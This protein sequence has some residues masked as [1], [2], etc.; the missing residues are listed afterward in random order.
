MISKQT[1][2]LFILGFLV[3]SLVTA[4]QAVPGYMD[5]DYYYA[6]A[7]RIANGKGLTEPFLWNY[8]EDSSRIVHPSHGYWMPLSSFIAAAG[9]V[10]SGARTFFAARGG[11]LLLAASIPPLTYHL[12]RR[13][14]ADQRSA[15]LAGVLACFSSF[16]LPYTSITETF[17]PYMVL[18]G[19]L[20]MA[21]DQFDQLRYAFVTGVLVGAMHLT[22]SEGLLWL[23]VAFLGLA[24]SAEV[25]PKVYLGVLVGYLAV[26]G[27][28]MIRNYFAFGNLLGSGGIQTLWITEYDQLFVYPAD[29]LSMKNWWDQGLGSILQSRLWALGLNLKTAL[30]VQGQV[31]L[32]PLVLYGGIKHRRKIQVKLGF[33]GWIGILLAMTFIFPFQGA[34][35]AFFHAGA[36]LQPLLWSVA[37]LGFAEFVGWGAAKRSWREGQAWRILGMGI[38]LLSLGISVA[39]V[40]TRVIGDDLRDP[41]WNQ[42]H[43]TYQVV[44]ETLDQLGADESDV[45]M[46]NNPPGYYVA[47]RQTSIVIPDGGLET[48]LAAANRY[49]PQYLVLEPNHPRGLNDLYRNP[50]QQD[51]LTYLLSKGEVHYFSFP[52][53]QE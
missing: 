23:F 50:D 4:F 19:L 35:G 52:Q 15:F 40:H 33:I 39:V 13:L 2:L 41:Q 21:F 27:P 24:L 22:R 10:V 1:I 31:F 48:L 25:R 16:Y 46:I 20:F 32:S 42:S 36:A 49:R 8:L 38:I 28:W 43:H 30:A 34:R 9:M 3:V 18:G 37:V 7:L 5:A 14:D 11:F 47:T 44:G 17:T 12:A 26:F 45:V 6:S 29:V 53:T 51:G